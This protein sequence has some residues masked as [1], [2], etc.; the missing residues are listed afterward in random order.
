MLR[1]DPQKISMTNHLERM[2]DN[3][4]FKKIEW[5]KHLKKRNR[6]RSKPLRFWL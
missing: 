1:I 2:S 5:L 3:R 6:R 4:K